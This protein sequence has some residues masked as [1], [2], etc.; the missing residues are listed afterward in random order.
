MA[1]EDKSLFQ[2][3]GSFK[4]MKGWLVNHKLTALGACCP[5]RTADPPTRTSAAHP[6]YRLRRMPHV[7][8]AAVHHVAGLTVA[9]D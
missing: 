1:A 3:L 4:D 6:A 5:L 8:A 7:N 9:A 2:S